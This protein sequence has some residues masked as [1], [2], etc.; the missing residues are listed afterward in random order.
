[1]PHLRA[2]LPISTRHAFALAF[3]LA[4][5][6]DAVNSLLVPLAL[7]APWI[8]ALAVLPPIENTSRPG[9]VAALTVTALLGDYVMLV[10]I[11]AML[12]FRARSVYNTA[13]GTPP[14]PASDCYALGLRR[15][16]WLIVTEIVRNVALLV[17]FPFFV[18]PS[19]FLAFRLSCATE[20]VVLDAKDTSGAFQRSFQ[21][22][23]GHFERWFEMVVVSTVL[24][25]GV[26]FVSALASL[27]FGDVSG[28]V[29]MTEDIARVLVTG[30]APVIQYAWTFFYLRMVE[31]D[32]Q[33]GL[34]V[35]PAQEP[36]SAP[37]AW[38]PAPASAFAPSGP[39]VV[40][41]SPA[42]GFI[43]PPPDFI[44]PTP[45]PGVVAPEPEIAQSASGNGH[46]PPPASAGTGL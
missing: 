40:E 4:F 33:A 5:R 6:R 31:I 12:R 38:A 34:D 16:P 37:G 17:A 14:A 18:L 7:R 15:M 21:L 25:L 44:A 43:T 24:V 46:A 8:M 19:V 28:P 36:A 39:G 10:L 22:T 9:V 32:R 1:M 35:S 27:P 41:H 26:L 2:R 45:G 29:R 13:P 3:D 20:A 23:K 11:G 30:I 42:P